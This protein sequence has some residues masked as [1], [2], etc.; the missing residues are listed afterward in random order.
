MAIIKIKAY[1]MWAKKHDC[2]VVCGTQNTPHLSQGMCRKCYYK[3]NEKKHS[4][5]DNQALN[6]KLTK[7]YLESKY[8]SDGCSLQDIALDSGWTRQ[9]VAKTMKHYN[10][11]FR[12]KATARNL[13]QKLGKVVNIDG[14][15]RESH[16][17]NSNFFK[18]WSNE[19]AY[20]L[21]FI[22]GDGCLEKSNPVVV[23]SQKEVEILEKIKTL[24]NSNAIIR[25]RANSGS[26]NNISFLSL[27]NKE[28][29]NDL[30]SLGLTPTKSKIM[31]YPHQMPEQYDSHFLRGIWDANGCISYL[32]GSSYKASLV[33]GSLSFC[34][35]VVS[36]LSYYGIRT[37]VYSKGG[38]HTIY[39]SKKSEVL[40]IKDLLYRGSTDM[41][42]L[43]RKREKFNLVA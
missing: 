26:K 5:E 10:I 9:Y 32:G 37:N 16:T 27:Y 30:L 22:W 2:C 23:V 35:S 40:K 25:T 7:E 39:L 14:S 33:T 1:N 41:T 34:C 17:C 31:T 38:N 21:G 3:N 43:N 15:Q 19:M 8:I 4:K 13:A 28:M 12:D 20:V 42:S 29:Y 6:T 24:L 36:R 11:P 18:V